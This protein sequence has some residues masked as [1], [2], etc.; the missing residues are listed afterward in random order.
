MAPVQYNVAA[1]APD[2]TN[3]G[4]PARKDQTV[5]HRVALP[6]AKPFVVIVQRHQVC[7]G[8]NLDPATVAAAGTRAARR[9]GVE[10][11]AARGPVLRRQS[12]PRPVPQALG[13]FQR[14]QFVEERNVDIGIGSETDCAPRAKIRRSV[15][16]PVT[17]ARFCDWTKPG[18]GTGARKRHRL[19]VRHLCTMDQAPPVIDPVMVQQPFRGTR[20]KMGQNLVNL[21]PLFG[22]MHVDRAR[23]RLFDDSLQP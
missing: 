14:L 13:V 16:D 18:H 19:G 9:G 10:Q 21:G 5:E 12:G 3:A 20:A 4:A 1:S 7:Q 15:E 8:A 11:D 17:E 23:R 2:V 6:V 22:K